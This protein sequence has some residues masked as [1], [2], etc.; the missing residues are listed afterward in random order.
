MNQT[1]EPLKLDPPLVAELVTRGIPERQ[2]EKLLLS[3]VDGQHV[4]DQLEW[5]DYL[6]RQK[7]NSRIVNPTGFYIHLVKEN[8]SPPEGFE[9]SRKRAIW[10]AAREEHV[11]RVHEEA[12]LELAYD[13]YKKQAL[14]D[15]ISR[16]YPDER[17]RDLIDRKMQELSRKHRQISFWKPEQATRF[18]DNAVRNDI[19]NELTL[20]SFESFCEQARSSLAGT[21]SGFMAEGGTSGMED[22]VPGA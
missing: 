13:E 18:A 1:E 5:G 20:M 11:R 3:V 16:Q 7:S 9:T 10:T 15:Y 12:A 21:E 14:D 8:V 4:M 2:A 17:Y 22:F 6:I 19:E